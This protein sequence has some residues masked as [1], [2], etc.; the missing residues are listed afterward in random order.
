[1]LLAAEEV[2]LT[3]WEELYVVLHVVEFDLV[4]ACGSTVLCFLFLVEC[5]GG[6]CSACICRNSL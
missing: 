5:N 2:E 3:V 4:V 1:L 6:L